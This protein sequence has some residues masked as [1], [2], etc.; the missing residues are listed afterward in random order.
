MQ[1]RKLTTITLSPNP[2]EPSGTMNIAYLA[3]NI[4][5]AIRRMCLSRSCEM[6]G[7]RNFDFC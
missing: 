5:S 6:Y 2:S 4:T 3:Y 1:K 7:S